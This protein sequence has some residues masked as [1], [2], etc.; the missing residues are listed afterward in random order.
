MRND[1]KER[2]VEMLD[3]DKAEMNE[4]SKAAAIADFMH[5]AGEYFETEGEP[6]FAVERV[7][8]G[9]RVSLTFQAVRVKNFST[10][11]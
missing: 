7:K 3:R 5:V 6:R 1:P 2:L 4:A 11:Q 9:Y 8:G 10:L